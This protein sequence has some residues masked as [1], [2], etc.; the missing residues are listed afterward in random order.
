M[1][2]FIYSLLKEKKVD[3]LVV[4]GKYNLPSW[5]L[6]HYCHETI[7]TSIKLNIISLIVDLVKKGKKFSDFSI[8]PYSFDLYPNKTQKS[9]TEKQSKKFIS[10]EEDS[11]IDCEFW[12]ILKKVDRPYVLIKDEEKWEPLLDFEDNINLKIKSIIV[13]SPPKITFE[14]IGSTIN[15]LRFGKEREVRTARESDLRQMSQAM[16]NFSKL[17]SITEQLENANISQ[18][19]KAYLRQLYANIVLK[20]IDLNERLGINPRQVNERV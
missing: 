19:N 5:T 3:S 18:G 9:F 12:R 8:I 1:F 17:L 13:N 4:E 15:D 10:I 7:N 11:F 20:Q 16:D 2:L 14:G 6:I